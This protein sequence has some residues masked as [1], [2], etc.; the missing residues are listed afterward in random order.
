MGFDGTSSFHV[1]IAPCCALGVA[2]AFGGCAMVVEDTE[3]VTGRSERVLRLR[4]VC[5]TPSIP[6]GTH[7]W[8]WNLISGTR[9]R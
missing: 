1:W 6:A 4:P 7:R 3:G 8:T 5:N 2:G 9:S